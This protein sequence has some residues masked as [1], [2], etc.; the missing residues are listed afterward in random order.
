MTPILS[1]IPDPGFMT[2]NDEDPW[3]SSIA[4]VTATAANLGLPLLEGDAKAVVCVL[5]QQRERLAIVRA[6]I[7][8]DPLCPPGD[9]G[10]DQQ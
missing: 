7:Q 6:A 9:F 5:R 1:L 10:M 8:A 2:L 4:S 3:P